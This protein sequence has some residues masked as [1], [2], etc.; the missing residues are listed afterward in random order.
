[1]VA[2]VPRKKTKRKAPPG[3]KH[4][5]SISDDDFKAGQKNAKALMRSL[6]QKVPRTPYNPFKEH[7]CQIAPSTQKTYRDLWAEMA[8]FF[9]LIGCYQSAIL[10]DR[11]ICP[12]SDPLPFR[13]E[14]FAMY[15]T[16]RLA[17]KGLPLIHPT[18]KQPI[19]DVHGRPLK[20]VGGW[21]APSMLYK[22]HAAVL[23]LHETMYPSSCSGEYE[24][25]CPTCAQMN[26]GTVQKLGLATESTELPHKEELSMYYDS[27]KRTLLAEKPRGLCK[28]IMHTYQYGFYR[29]CVRHANKPPLRSKGNVLLHPVVNNTYH[30]WLKIKQNSHKVKG[31]G[32]LYPSE[33]RKLREHLLTEADIASVQMWVMI[34]LAVRLFLRC[35]ELISL[36]MDQFIHEY[37]PIDGSPPENGLHV[38]TKCQVVNDMAVES[39]A[40]EIQGKCDKESFR[41]CLYCDYQYPD[42]DELRHLL[43]YLKWFNIKGGYLFPDPKYL[44]QQY[45]PNGWSTSPLRPDKPM[46]Y[47][48]F[49]RRFKKLVEKILQRDVKLFLVGT[50]TLR[51]T[52]YLLAIWG[53]YFAALYGSEIAIPG[54]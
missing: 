3:R 48:D 15:L 12:T 51:K 8:R 20:A 26:R 43:F 54:T 32:Q 24:D 29:S 41:L 49:H 50:H 30:A 25:M 21:N 18:T 42:F 39:V 23:F 5:I 53:F 19:L 37:Y 13:P 45:G 1:M 31:C 9:Y 40:C 14:S 17:K 6:R 38:L 47:E 22:C 4:V 35:D 2:L 44:S 27:D 52:A 10:A 11:Q 33:L 7:H 28:F 16:Y 36:R 34:L 46:K